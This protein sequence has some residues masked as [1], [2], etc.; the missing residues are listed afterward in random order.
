MNN[1]IS[2]CLDCCLRFTPVQ[3]RSS[4]QVLQGIHRRNQQPEKVTATI[5]LV[6]HY[7]R[8][9][10]ALGNCHLVRAVVGGGPPARQSG[11]W[12]LDW[13]NPFV[14]KLSLGAIHTSITLHVTYIE[15]TKHA[16]HYVTPHLSFNECRTNQAPAHSGKSHKTPKS[17]CH[18]PIQMVSLWTLGNMSL[19]H[20]E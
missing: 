15:S 14:A 2:I 13:T 8:C 9:Q 19:Q 11:D 1:P 6:R 5:W 7:R 12:S 10:M 4:T 17:C 18:L 3:Y 20:V 16:V